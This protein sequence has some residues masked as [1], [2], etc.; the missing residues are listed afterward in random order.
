SGGST[1]VYANQLT[2]AGDWSYL[3]RFPFAQGS[4]G[5]I[6]IM[7]SFPEAGS[8]AV[9]DGIKLAFAGGTPPIAPSG[10]AGAGT[11]TSRVDLFWTDNSTNETGF[12]VA[13]ATTTGGPYTDL[14][15]L[16]A[17]TT[18]YSDTS[19]S[20]NTTYYYVVRVFSEGGSSANSS[21]ATATT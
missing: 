7:D 20:P 15:A 4:S 17:N 11:S 3:G 18:S 13:R 6:R 2:N 9:A 8:V 12:I 16:V 19:L 14:P 21:E 5:N 1:T 10:L